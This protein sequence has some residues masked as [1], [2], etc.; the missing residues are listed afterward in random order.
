LIT[1]EEL[2]DVCKVHGIR[3]DNVSIVVE[4]S[5]GEEEDKVH[6]S[7]VPSSPNRLPATEH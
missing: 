4:K 2:D 7:N 1:I 3:E 6:G 5:E